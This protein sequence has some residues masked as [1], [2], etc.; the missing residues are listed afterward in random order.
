M[1]ILIIYQTLSATISIIFLFVYYYTIGFFLFPLFFPRIGIHKS[2]L[3][4]KI[5]IGI[6]SNILFL[7]IWNL[8]FPISRIGFFIFLGI[9]FFFGFRFYSRDYIN[10]FLPNFSFIFFILVFIFSLWLGF[11]SNNYPGPSD[12]GRNHLQVMKLAE[13]YALIKGVGNLYFGLAYSCSSWLLTAQFN[14]LF[15]TKLFIWTHGS[16]YLLLG[17]INFFLIP[18]FSNDNK[19]I[20]NVLRILYFPILIH[21]CFKCFPG[22]SSDLPVLFYTAILS[23]YYFKYFYFREQKNLDIIFIISVLGI[24]N[25]LTFG[26]VLIGLIPT[27]IILIIDRIKLSTIFYRFPIWIALVTFIFWSYRNVIMTGYPFFPFSEISFPVEWRMDELRVAELKNQ[28][29]IS[30]KGYTSGSNKSVQLNWYLGRLTTQHI[31]VEL[32]YPIIM[33]IVGFVYSVLFLRKKLGQIFFLVLPSLTSIMFWVQFPDNRFFSSSFW[34]FGS[35]SSIFFIDKT[36]NIIKHNIFLLFVII[37]SFSIHIFDRLGSPKNF[38]PLKIRMNF[39][40][41]KLQKTKNLHGF[42]YHYP[43]N[44]DECWESP[45]PCS[46]ENKNLLKKIILINENNLIDGLK[47][48]K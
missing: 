46:P 36:I 40:K 28:I 9:C 7:Y 37:L 11:L 42:S 12:L 43:L 47:E 21:Y 22:T 2:R 39:P 27:L 18:I 45:F 10:S 15:T 23:I 44:N 14:T 25:K 35:M 38:F 26:I 20:E 19:K 1:L 29:M 5:F 17:F 3:N 31:R 6:I 13:D 41:A 32:L 16:I 33:G 48:K 34:W 30:A 4:Q 24:T 8:F